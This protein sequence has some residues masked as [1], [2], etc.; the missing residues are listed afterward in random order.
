MIIDDDYYLWFI[1]KISSKS[2]IH[3]Y[4]Y[5]FICLF[6]SYLWINKKIGADPL[7][8]NKYGEFPSDIATERDIHFD[9]DYVKYEIFKHIIYKDANELG[10][11]IELYAAY[12][13]L[14][15]YDIIEEIKKKKN[16]LKKLLNTQLRYDQ[17]SINFENSY[18]ISILSKHKEQIEKLYFQRYINLY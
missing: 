14:K 12:E 2:S 13:D 6:I 7:I 11:P 8:K 9:S 15:Y 4:I 10:L 16:E 3:T 18:D 5:I 1:I 17:T